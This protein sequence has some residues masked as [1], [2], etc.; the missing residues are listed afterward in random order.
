MHLLYRN[1]PFYLKNTFGS[2]FFS[3]TVLFSRGKNVGIQGSLSSVG[4]NLGDVR[5]TVFLYCTA[6][7]DHICSTSS[8][9]V[10]IAAVSARSSC[11]D[12]CSQHLSLSESVPPLS[13]RHHEEIW[14]GL[15][16]CFLLRRRFLNL[17]FH[18]YPMILPN[19]GFKNEFLICFG[20]IS[21]K[22]GKS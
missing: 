21:A 18:S 1:A 12:F 15:N 11:F 2:N 4:W 8:C 10:F 7:N 17:S 13:P 3:P 16:A 19:V 5:L 20:C 6:P 22:Y 9:N 14:H